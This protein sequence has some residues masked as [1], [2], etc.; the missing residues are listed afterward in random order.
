MASAHEYT[1][2]GWEALPPGVREAMTMEPLRSFRE[3][4]TPGS[5]ELE[6]MGGWSLRELYVF[7]VSE[8]IAKGHP[9]SKKVLREDPSF[10]EVVEDKAEFMKTRLKACGSYGANRN[11]SVLREYGLALRREDKEPVGPELG[12]QVRG[13]MAAIARAL[14]PSGRGLCADAWRQAG[15]TIVYNGSQPILEDPRLGGAFHSDLRTIVLRST[16][17]GRPM[18]Y[19]GHEVAHLL[20]FDGR[21]PT[22]PA[23]HSVYRSE[24]AV[25]APDRDRHAREEEDLYRLAVANMTCGTCMGG[26]GWYPDGFAC[27]T[28][29]GGC[30]CHPAA[31]TRK[32]VPVC[33]HLQAQGAIYR[34]PREVWARLVEQYIAWRTPGAGVATLPASCYLDRPTY[35]D[36]AAFEWL[37]PTIEAVV[38]RRIAGWGR[39]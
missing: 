4:M 17:P 25:A 39:K 9:V 14:D 8:A 35:W 13:A 10:L 30:A 16:Y 1:F 32:A 27:R 34:R 18:C 24:A 37:T 12:E 5:R 7:C 36:E 28:S 22:G 3:T 31:A 11:V 26:C 20:D 21:Q 6:G 19:L 15:V 2:E 23:D 33:G 29:P 38:G